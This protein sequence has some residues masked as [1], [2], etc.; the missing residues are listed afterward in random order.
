MTPQPILTA[1][2]GRRLLFFF[3][4]CLSPE[5]ARLE[6][7]D[8]AMGVVDSGDGLIWDA[9]GWEEEYPDRRPT[10]WCEPPPD[11]ATEPGKL[12]KPPKKAWFMSYRVAPSYRKVGQRDRI[13]HK[14]TFVHPLRMVEEWGK[15]TGEV[16]LAVLLNYRE[17]TPD[18]IP[19]LGGDEGDATT[20]DCFDNEMYVD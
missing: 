2:T 19:L 4:A 7:P 8:W 9:Q 10:H 20:M 5:G 1:P 3:P 12:T 11:P 15:L 16:E 17:L 13:G 6:E 18:E 14:V